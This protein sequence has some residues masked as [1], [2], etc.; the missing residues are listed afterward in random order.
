[1][2]IH[3]FEIE[4]L[5]SWIASSSRKPLIIRGARQVGKSNLVRQL[6]L[7]TNRTCFELNF[8][9]YPE[10]A[11]FFASKDPV[12]IID[13]LSIHFKKVI[14]L[15]HAILF[16]D[17]IQ[18][19]PQLI[20]ILRYFYE[21]CSQL[22]VIAAGSLLDFALEQPNFSV[23]VGRVEYLHLEPISFENFLHALGEEALLKWIQSVT[24][25]DNVPLPI[26]LKCFEFI[27][28]YWL[29]GG[30]PEVVASFIENR[31]FQK[32]SKIKQ[33]I[34]ISY[35]DDFYKYGR[36]QRLPQLRNCFS[37]IPN[38]MGQKIKYANLDPDVKSSYVKEAIHQLSLAKIIYPVY[39]THANGIP[40]RAQI[41]PKIFKVI[42]VDIGLLS[43]A[44]GLTELSI[45]N[46]SDKDW[47]NRGGLAEQF[48]GQTLLYSQLFYSKPELFYWV[49]EKAQSSAEID[50]VIQFES[51]TIPIEV[52]AG[53]SGRLKSLQYFIKEKQLPLGIRFNL[54][55]P[56]LLEQQVELPKQGPYQF[57]L[58]SLPLYL[59]GQ[60]NRFLSDVFFA[61]G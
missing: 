16:L 9:R 25:S 4:I 26:H 12:K 53:S 60:L 31:D 38:F 8:E 61:K 57:S 40:L 30:M 46:I 29:V 52:K 13:L 42:F 17:E 59:A 20:E 3:R 37:Q 23:P 18:A 58:L 10:H 27:K 1:M 55:T 56:S 21:E 5:E 28:L 34:L 51:R 41:N 44:V 43:T 22:P 7:H 39:H 50:Y 24:L 19:A 54:D 32:I 33:D 11:Q 15:E 35:E 47:I 49:R 45:L 36:V 14:D 6:A 48:I 2:Q